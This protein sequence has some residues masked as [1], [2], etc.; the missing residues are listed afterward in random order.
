LSNFYSNLNKLETILNENKSNLALVGIKPT[1]PSEKY[2]YIIPKTK[3][4]VSFVEEFKEKPDKFLAQKYI[5]K[6]ALWNSG[7]FAFKI[8][9][10][11]KLAHNFINFNDY[12]DL[13]SMYDSLEKISFDYAVVEKEKN[14]QVVKFDGEWKDVGTWNTLA[15]TMSDSVKG[16]VVMGDNNKNCNVINELDIPVFCMGCKD[17]VV[18]ASNDGILVSDKEQSSYIK[19]YVDKISNQIMS[20]EKSWGYFKVLDIQPNCMTIKIT[21]NK[22]QSMSY[23]SHENRDEIWNILS[24]KATVV[25]DDKKIEVSGGDSIKIK[26]GTKHTIIA[27]T[28]INLIEIQTGKD[29]TNHDKIKHDLKI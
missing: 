20:L 9:Y 3:E 23:H 28:D 1:Y 18:V 2:G 27:K 26:A 12:Q 16:N 21:L 24:G 17:L 4:Q 15:E 7:I 10:V 22:D 8:G 29:L 14:I 13:F 6:G 19:P 5:E 25:L 11:L